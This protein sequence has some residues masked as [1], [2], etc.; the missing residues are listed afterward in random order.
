MPDTQSTRYTIGFAAAVC[1]VC[2]LLV[3]ASA[4]GLREKQETNQLLYRQKNVLLAAGVVKP[5]DDLSDNVSSSRCSIATSASASSTFGPATWS[6][7]ARWMRRPTTSARRGATRPPRTRRRPTPRRYRGCRTYGTVYYVVDAANRDRV[8]Q[9]VIPVEGIGMW[10]TMYG[11]LAIDR[12]TTTISGL[13]YYDQKET[14]GLG[15]EAGSARWQ[16]LWRGRKAYDEN[17]EP[18]IVVIK[19]PAGPARAGPAS[20]RRA[21][22]RDDHQ[23]RHHADDAVLAEQGRLRPV[24]EEVPRRRTVVT[25]V[26]HHGLRQAAARRAARR[27]SSRTTRSA[28]RCSASARRSPSRRASTRPS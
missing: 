14:P 24:P 18:R 4:V 12:D 16:A 8:E 27:R 23:Q 17:W 2:A 3:A 25:L 20:C 21:V 10:G 11:F 26:R 13:T 7:R 15:G 28:C 19:G 9:I 5:G 22:G 6:P 1:V